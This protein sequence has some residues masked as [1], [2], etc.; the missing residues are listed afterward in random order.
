MLW[1][2]IS[3]GWLVL[4]YVCGYDWPFFFCVNG[5]IWRVRKRTAD[6]LTRTDCSV[7]PWAFPVKALQTWLANVACEASQSLLISF[8]CNFVF[9]THLLWMKR[10]QCNIININKNVYILKHLIMRENICKDG[11]LLILDYFLWGR[12]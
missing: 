10:R 6:V 2:I 7:F 12:I 8:Q 4:T 5:D 11:P 1:Y 9:Y 3:N